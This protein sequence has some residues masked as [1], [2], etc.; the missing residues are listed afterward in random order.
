M[1]TETLPPESE[2]TDLPGIISRLAELPA[3]A[4][5]TER[6]LC[7]IFGKCSASIK[8]AVDRGELP[9]PVKL[10]GKPTWTAGNIIAH[11]EHR[12]ETEQRKFARMVP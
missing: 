5:V 9:R 8:A 7:E 12:L 1:K 3:G 4:L 11:H 6:G 10:M 2:E